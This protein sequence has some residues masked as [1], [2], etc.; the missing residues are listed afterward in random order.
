MKE[1]SV[2]MFRQLICTY[3]ALQNIE[4]ALFETAQAIEK[5]F[6][7]GGKLLAC[8]NGGS[9]ADADHI[10][11]ELMKGFRLRRPLLQASRML[12][13]AA[14]PEE[15]DYLVECL[16]EA[17]PAISLCSHSS[18][19]SAFSNDVQPDMVYAQQVYGYGRAGDVLVAISTSGN[20]ANVANAVRV[21][22][23]LDLVTIGLTGAAQSKLS[24]LCNITLRVPETETFRVQELHLPVYHALCAVVENQFFGA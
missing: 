2:A 4:P 6:R 7:G 13:S 22:R 20:A 16:Q 19:I 12:L 24:T 3:P 17:L 5:C 18:L 9:C 10:V 23:A 11:G 15:S 21:A 1:S 8:G 14:C